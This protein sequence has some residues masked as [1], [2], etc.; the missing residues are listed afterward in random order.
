MLYRPKQEL[1]WDTWLFQHEED[2]YLF[3]IRIS[4]TDIPHPKPTI[5]E[6]WNGISLARSK[7]LLHWEEIGPIQEMHAESALQGTGMVYQAD[8]QFVMCFCEERPVGNSVICFASSQDLIN[9]ERLPEKYEIRADTRYYQREQSESADPIPRWGDLGVAPPEGDRN[10]YL[11]FTVSNARGTRPGECGTLG[12]LTSQ[13]G[14]KWEAMPPVVAPGLFAS[15]EVPEYVRF[16]ERHY[17]LF[18]TNSTA[19]PRFDPYAAGPHSGAY[20]VVSDAA[21]GPYVRPPHDCLLMGQRNTNRLFGTYVGRPIRTNPDQIL[22]YHQWS[23]EYPIGWA[24][25]PKVLV[26]R[27]PYQLGLDYWPGCDALKGRTLGDGVVDGAL[28]PLEA[29]GQ[30][31]VID[32]STSNGSVQAVNQGGMNGVTWEVKKEAPSLSYTD[33]SDGRILETGIRIREGRGLGFWFGQHNDADPL[34]IMLNAEAGAVEIGTL[35]YTRHGA[36]YLFQPDETIA[37]PIATGVQHNLRILIRQHF[38]EIYLDDRFVHA[39][40]SQQEADTQ[41]LGFCAELATGDFIVPRI[42]SMA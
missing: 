28:T 21:T 24:S 36:S 34:A 18:S 10:E 31:P 5:G 37:W 7:D 11:G 2:Y 20:Y 15:Y 35:T 12:L 41:Y 33:L 17:V 3:Y 14:L 40:V 8:N 1:L 38:V 25:T 27:A 32:W 19:A 26:E 9:W 23:A 39:Y 16:G 13:D 30:V 29:A 6:G 22:Y 4:E 42:W